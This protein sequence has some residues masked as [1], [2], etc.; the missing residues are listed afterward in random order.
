MSAVQLAP[1]HQVTAALLHLAGHRTPDR[2]AAHLEQAGIRGPRGA[3]ATCPIAEH[4]RQQT[5]LAVVVGTWTWRLVDHR[6]SWSL[7]QPI[8]LFV[9]AY[10]GGAYPGLESNE[11][12]A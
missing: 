9:N 11:A 7:P 4:I 10:D 5:G 2:I 3:C 6:D 12:T 8:A 1:E